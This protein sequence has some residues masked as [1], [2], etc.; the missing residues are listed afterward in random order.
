MMKCADDIDVFFCF[1][2]PLTTVQ[3]GQ[4]R[5]P[6]YPYTY[7]ENR[8][9]SQSFSTPA[10]F[11]VKAELRP[12]RAKTDML[13]AA[14]AQGAGQGRAGRQ[15]HKGRGGAGQVGEVGGG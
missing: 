6:T 14:K 13:R 9:S 15:R 12:M 10:M 3:H 8:M 5:M 2:S 1:S 11:M 7:M 4:C